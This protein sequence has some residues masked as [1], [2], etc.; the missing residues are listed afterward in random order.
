MDTIRE[1]YNVAVVGA[2]IAGLTAAFLL[3][4]HANVTVFEKSNRAGGWIDTVEK[5]GFLIERGP[6]ILRQSDTLTELAQK[7][8]LALEVLPPQRRYIYRGGRLHKIALWKYPGLLKDLFCKPVDYEESIGAFSRRHFGERATEELVD[9]MVMGIFGGDK[10]LLSFGDCF[11]K[12]KAL[13]QRYGSLI[14]GMIK[15]RTPHHLVRFPGGMKSL[16]E[17]LKARVWIEYGK[18]ARLIQGSRLMIDDTVRGYDAVI[19]TPPLI[20]KRESLDLVTLCWKRER[21]KVEGFGFLVPSKEGS[22][23][24]GAT[25]NSPQSVTFM[26]RGRDVAFESARDILGMTQSPDVVDRFRAHEAIPQYELG[27]FEQVRRLNLPAKVHLLGAAYTGVGVNDCID[28]AFR[29][30]ST[31]CASFSAY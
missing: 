22:S 15:E 18:E 27:Y 8:G 29:L 31:L 1:P 19:W 14:K 26:M 17:A 9:P 7:L 5:E 24:L 23:L 10:E 20:G 21:L 13:E 28:A 30:R 3:S 2:G 11:P 16:V 25:F 6:R 12:L 4:E